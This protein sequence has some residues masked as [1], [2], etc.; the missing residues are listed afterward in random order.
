MSDLDQQRQIALEEYKQVVAQ[1]RALTDI[2][3]KLITYLP[4]GAVATVYASKDGQLAEQPAVAA[5]ALVVTLCI[6]VYNKRND[7]HY[8]ELVARAAELEREELGLPHGSFTQRPTSWLRYG[9]LRVEHRW[10]IGLVYTAAAALWAYLLV[11]GLLDSGQHGTHQPSY[12]IALE[13][14]APVLVIAC[15]LW[16]R[17]IERTAQ[18]E[19]RRAVRSLKDVFATG[20]DQQKAKDEILKE[21]K[22]LGVCEPNKLGFCK[23]YKKEKELHDKVERRVKYHWKAYESKPDERAGSALLGAVID[24]LARWIEDVW[25]GRR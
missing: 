2:R 3:F 8:D 4:L 19:L 5:F 10:P 7:Q 20:P 22:A 6:A 15:W 25:S 23:R 9:P 21:G 24:H 14:A 16:L 13:L 11:R 1:F 17:Y 12:K 18:E